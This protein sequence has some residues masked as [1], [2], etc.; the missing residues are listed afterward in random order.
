M[1]Q[2]LIHCL[3]CLAPIC[4][5][6]WHERAKRELLLHQL[7]RRQMPRHPLASRVG[8]LIV[9][10]GTR[11]QRNSRSTPITSGWLPTV[12]PCPGCAN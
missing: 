8:R 5:S 2:R 4:L 11:L 12:D 9:R 7:R 1:G 3:A 10:V 6:E